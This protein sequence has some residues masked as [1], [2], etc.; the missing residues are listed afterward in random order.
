MV[1]EALDIHGQGLYSSY[2]YEYPM[3]ELQET[4]FRHSPD[5]DT[6]NSKELVVQPLSQGA[7]KYFRCLNCNK[8]VMDYKHNR[9]KYCSKKCYLEH[10]IPPN[11]GKTN[12][13]QFSCRVCSKTFF[14]WVFRK[15]C[16]QECYHKIPIWNKGKKNVYSKKVRLKMSET[17]K[18]LIREGKLK[19]WWFGKINPNY[20]TGVKEKIA[21][22]NKGNIAWNKGKKGVQPPPPIKGLTFDDF[23]GKHKAEQIK[24]KI[25]DKRKN[26]K[27]PKSFTKPERILI[28]IIKK[29]SLPYRYTG[30]GSFWIENINPDF[31]D[32][33][34]KKVA[35]EVFGDYWHNPLMRIGLKWHKTEVGRKEIYKKYGWKSIILWEKDIYKGEKNILKIIK[36]GNENVT[37][38]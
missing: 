37:R 36:G 5:L 21:K 10:H 9:I 2:S 19:L 38:Q 4:L 31:V 8:G 1:S 17:K 22:A 26:Q 3:V 33:N 14:S 34:G 20:L 7:K 24:E 28:E 29:H 35:L 32:C 12:K 15:Y 25:R 11:K 18:R 13:K 16:S 6:S 30:D 23:Y 27:I